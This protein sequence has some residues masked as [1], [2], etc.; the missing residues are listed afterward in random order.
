M[1][2]KLNWYPPAV[3]NRTSFPVHPTPAGCSK[4]RE[5]AWL[6]AWEDTPLW[7]R[8][9]LREF[10]E[11]PP[12]SMKLSRSGQSHDSFAD[13]SRGSWLGASWH[14]FSKVEDSGHR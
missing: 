13:G 1:D 14:R 12:L 7:A 2:S 5:A 11:S 4:P 9:S 8:H 10:S 3:L 6:S